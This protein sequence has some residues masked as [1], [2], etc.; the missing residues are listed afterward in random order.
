[1]IKTVA[2]PRVMALSAKSCA[3]AQRVQWSGTDLLKGSVYAPFGPNG[4][5][6]WG[7]SGATLGSSPPLNQHLRIFDKDYR[8]T[9]IAS[10]P[11]G[12]NRNITWDQANRITGIKV[13]SGLTLPGITN[14]SS[15]NQAFAYD[16]LDRLTTFNAGV[17]GATTLATGLGLL[18]TETFTYDGIGN[19]KTRTTQAPGTTT[20]QS[21][22]YAHGNTTPANHWLT[23]LT[24]A[25]VWTY[26]YDAAGNTI[27]EGSD[28]SGAATTQ[29]T[30]TYDAKNRLESTAI[31]STGLDAVAY[32]INAMGQRVQ[33]IGAGAYAF[34]AATAT[35][36]AYNARFVY[37]ESGNLLGEYAPDGKLMSETIW[38]ND[39]PVATLRPKGSN[40]GLPLGITGTG[41][42]TANN[43]G[44]NTTANKVNVEVYYL[45]P[46]HLGTPRVMTRSV[47]QA[48]ATT[49]PNAVN[50][51]VWS[52]NSDPFGTTAQTSTAGSANSAPNKNPQLVTG[53]AAQI[54]AASYEQNLRMPGQYEDQETRK[55]YNY[56]RDY[57][58]TI[59]RYTTSDPIGL[60]GGT[61]TF[62]YV[63]QHP[64]NMTDPK[65]LITA[66]EGYSHYCN[67]NG[68]TMTLSMAEVGV[69][70]SAGSFPGVR[71][72]GK[73]C[74][75]ATYNINDSRAYTTQGD[76]WWVLGDV[77]LRLQGIL[78]TRC[79]CSFT[80]A[81]NMTI[82]D[83]R[84]NFNPSIHRSFLGESATTLGRWGGKVCGST[85]YTIKFTGSQPINQSGKLLG[86]STCCR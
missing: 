82:D 78:N 33:K 15:L 29:Y 69:N 54:A 7:N 25:N 72:A 10:D 65:G 58:A 59:G 23:G 30:L 11:E 67:G 3:T 41:A 9:A 31:G 22:S 76:I 55:L 84:Y 16:Q 49:G 61:N 40:S 1:M 57:D 4:G 28:V 70:V 46:D 17:N 71:G 42:A 27:R 80:F 44:N 64:V 14:A 63:L 48:G 26:A 43:V 13:P 12:Y 35:S 38:F 83:D 66:A 8:P 19:R 51:Q 56:F 50:K 2:G 45:H 34:N 53:T 77:T 68:A 39:L 5:W 81:G 20:T 47:A 62:G 85:P 74:M 86:T 6:T 36:F 21:T 75:D 73:P 37:D 79:D 24:G 32:K 52:W 60:R 18:P